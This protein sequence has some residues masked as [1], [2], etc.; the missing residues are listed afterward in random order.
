MQLETLGVD[1]L[2]FLCERL[3]FKDLL[4]V[5]ATCKVIFCAILKYI[6]FIVT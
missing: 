5:E 2:E 6:K 4:Y 1:I 3:N